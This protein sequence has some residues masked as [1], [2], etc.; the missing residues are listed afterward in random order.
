MINTTI[1]GHDKQVILNTLAEKTQNETMTDAE[2]ILYLKLA[3]EEAELRNQRV[4]YMVEL[5]QL[6]NISFPQ[7]MSE[8][9][10]KPLPNV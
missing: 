3:K 2:N 4:A 5:S 1:L 9:G 6:R 10:L 8:L 7:L